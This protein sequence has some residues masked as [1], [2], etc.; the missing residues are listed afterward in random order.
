MNKKCYIEIPNP[1]TSEFIQKLAFAEE[2][3]DTQKSITEHQKEIE[4]EKKLYK[5]LKKKYEKE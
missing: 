2:L 3:K 1:K 4:R 5:K